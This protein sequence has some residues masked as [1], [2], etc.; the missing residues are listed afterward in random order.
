MKVS[1]GFTLI[2]L[3]VV[4]AIMA[5]IGVFTLSNFSSFGDNKKLDNAVLDI[6]SQLRTAQSNATSNVQCTQF[7]ATWQ[8]KFKSDA[9]TTNLNCQNPQSTPPPTIKKTSQLGTNI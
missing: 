4:M 9:V 2:E 1:A 7:S 8:V 5:I 3:M 6:Q